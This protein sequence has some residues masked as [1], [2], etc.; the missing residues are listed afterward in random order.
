[1]ALWLQVD[2]ETVDA[3][4][5]VFSQPLR[6]RSTERYRSIYTHA[7]LAVDVCASTN[8]IFLIVSDAITHPP[9][10]NSAAGTNNLVL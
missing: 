3:N 5:S 7:L 6:G 2:N 8:A 4:D 9:G 10:H 1:M